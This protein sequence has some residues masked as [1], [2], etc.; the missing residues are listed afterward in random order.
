MSRG[1][2]RGAT[3]GAAYL[4]TRCG[5]KSPGRRTPMLTFYTIFRES[6]DPQERKKGCPRQQRQVRRFAETW[7]GGPHRIYE[8]HAQVIESASQGSRREGELAVD[9]GIELPPRSIINE[10]LFPEVD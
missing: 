4:G 3:S 6:S 7:T 9:Q 1:Y 10:F 8:P 5:N 2:S